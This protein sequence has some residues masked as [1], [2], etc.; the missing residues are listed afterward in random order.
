MTLEKPVHGFLDEAAAA[1]PGSPAVRDARGAWTYAE[2]DGLSRAFEGWLADQGVGP[3][4]RVLVRLPNLRETAAMLYGTSRRGAVFVP[5]NPGMKD[6]HLGPVLADSEPAV[7]IVDDRQTA[8]MAALTDAPVHG[9]REVWEKVEARLPEPAREPAAVTGDAL[10]V[11]IYTS[12]STAAP[13]AVA[14]PHAQISFAVRGIGDMLGHTA[15]DVFYV[16]LPL[17]F[18]YGLFQLLLSA[19]A[20][21]ELVLSGSEP[22]YTLLERIRESGTTVLPVVPALAQLLVVLGERDPG[23]SAV[24]LITNTGAA[25]PQATIDALRTVFPGA[26]VARMYGITECKRVSIMPP[27]QDRERPG[28]VGLPLPGTRVLILDEDGTE[29]PPG[30]TGEIVP[31]GPHVM[32]GYWR[33]PELT[34]RTFRPDPRTG[35]T[36]LHTRDFGHL[37]EDGYLYFDGR[38]DDMFKRKGIR[39]STIEIEAAAT[40]I[41]GVRNAAALQPTEDRDLVLCV[42]TDLAPGVVLRELAKR[43]EAAK[44]PSVCRVLDAFPLTPNGKTAKDRLAALVE[45]DPR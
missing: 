1:A 40:D 36:R 27:D 19:D 22:E 35:E 3:G 44:V 42:V 16:R 9:L 29:L 12:G 28:S 38:R 6:Y 4:D 5:I 45:E 13:K 30:R 11:L 18:D 26:K 25:L 41:P 24:R 34:A 8:A 10:A 15:D 37:D 21:A 39:M 43:L 7:V 33:A 31:V 20:R 32:A 17:P 23:P 14:C 2:L